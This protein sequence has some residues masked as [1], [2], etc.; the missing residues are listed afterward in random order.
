MTSIPKY[1]KLINIL[2][3]S[4]RSIAGFGDIKMAYSAASISLIVFTEVTR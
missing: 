4:D 2:F 3:P 1:I